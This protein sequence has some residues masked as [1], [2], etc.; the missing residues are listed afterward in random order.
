MIHKVTKL[1][2]NHRYPWP[3]M[4]VGDVFKVPDDVSKSTALCLV[5][6]ANDRG[7]KSGRKFASA[8]GWVI[9]I[10]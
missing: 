5:T 4:D 3:E 8:K 1:E 9:R 2:K 7:V 6:N 10:Q